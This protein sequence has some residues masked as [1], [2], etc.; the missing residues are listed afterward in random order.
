MVNGH[1]HYPE[2]PPWATEDAVS[3]WLRSG[4]GRS[5]VH[6]TYFR[7]PEEYS[8][9]IILVVGAGPSGVDIVTLSSGHAKKVCLRSLSP[10]AEIVDRGAF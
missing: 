7:G 2:F 9:K 6:S 8:G 1:H 4:N 5:V 3:K 10:P